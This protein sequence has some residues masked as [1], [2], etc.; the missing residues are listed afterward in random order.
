MKIKLAILDKDISYLNRMVSAFG[1][2]YADKLELYSFSDEK[3]AMESLEVNKIDLLL[4]S[5][6]FDIDTT[7]LPRR[8][9]FA[10]LVDSSDIETVKN[11]VAICK[12]QKADLIYKQILSLY[13]E[14]ASNISGLKLN[15]TDSKIIIFSSPCG[16]TGTSTMAAA[17]AKQLARGGKKVLYLDLQLYGS[18]DSFF[19]GEGQFDMSDI[20]YALKSKKANTSLKIESCLK[21]DSSGVYFFSQ[22]KVVLD[23][24]ELDVEDIHRL[25]SE[26]RIS[27]GFEYIIV[28]KDFGISKSDFE[29]YS[30][31]NHIVIVG[32]G[33][34]I[35]NTKVV[36]AYGAIKTLEQ[37]ID[38]SFSNRINII[39][40]KF[41]NKTGQI[42]ENIELPNSTGAPRFQHATEKDVVEQLATM[43]LFVALV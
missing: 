33:S 20:I 25:I 14:K 27:S 13:S 35:S 8:C 7:V 34:T 41:S 19:E 30:Q 18:V 26:I 22:P 21:R 17:C 29:I 1:T 42:I 9:A 11:Q 16:G 31:A 23:M 15:D 4:T 39:Y 38:V 36:N 6:L 2:K 32:D 43:S 40:N 10:Y 28:D 24:L 37:N 3:I 5:D 12:F